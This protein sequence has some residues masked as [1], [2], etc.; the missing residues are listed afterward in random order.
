[1]RDTLNG[2]RA[3]EPAQPTPLVDSTGPAPVELT[4]REHFNEYFEILPADTPELIRRTQEI[5]YQVYCVEHPFENAA[6]H[7]DGLETDEY[8]THAVHTLLM[9]RA[10]GEA[11]GTVRLVLPLAE[12]P[13]RSFAIQRAIDHPIFRDAARFPLHS[14]GEV[15]RFSISKQFRRRAN[16]TLYGQTDEAP[17]SPDHP[18]RRSNAPLTRLGLIQA[19]IRLTAANR[20]TH[21]CAMMEPRLLRMLATTSIFFEPIGEL[22]EFHGLRQP[23]YCDVVAMLSRVQREQPESWDVLT[24]GGALWEPLLDAWRAR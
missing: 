6:D 13:E 15:S 23:C 16:D 4:P 2:M 3:P 9:H 14:T 21:W 1:M 17:R 8:D 7:P 10:S 5:R 12:A 19:L 22:V 24:D 11:M 18:G 20:I